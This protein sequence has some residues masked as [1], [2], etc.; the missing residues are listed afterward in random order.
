VGSTAIP[1]TPRVWAI[2]AGRVI[3]DVTGETVSGPDSLALLGP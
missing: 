3:D 1:G 2:G